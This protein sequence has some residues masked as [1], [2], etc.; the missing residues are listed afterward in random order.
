[1]PANDSY[2]TAS[3]LAEI[4][5]LFTELLHGVIEAEATDPA[6]CILLHLMKRKAPSASTTASTMAASAPMTASE[7]EGAWTAAAW[8]SSVD[9]CSHA[10]ARALLHCLL[11]VPPRPGW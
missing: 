10:L 4:E 8:L 11:P 6:D 3:R 2:T 7:G 1:M 9:T 5:Q